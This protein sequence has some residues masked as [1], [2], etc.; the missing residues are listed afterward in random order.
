V[1]T[2]E[3]TRKH[4]YVSAHASALRC[5]LG[6]KFSLLVNFKMAANRFLHLQQYP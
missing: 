5:D 6:Q 4:C 2:S 1:S 3:L